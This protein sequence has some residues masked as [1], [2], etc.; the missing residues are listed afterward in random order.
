MHNDCLQVVIPSIRNVP[1][2]NTTLRDDSLHINESRLLPGH[3]ATIFKTLWNHKLNSFVHWWNGGYTY[4]HT[5]EVFMLM[6]GPF[7]APSVLVNIALSWNPYWHVYACIY[8]PN[9]TL[10]FIVQYIIH[11]LSRNVIN[12]SKN[13]LETSSGETRNATMT[14]RDKGCAHDLNVGASIPFKILIHL[15]D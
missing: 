5:N 11:I 3:L 1:F 7:I 6:W 15:S 4:W 9:D 13:S 8:N 2:S 12:I 14:G 10:N